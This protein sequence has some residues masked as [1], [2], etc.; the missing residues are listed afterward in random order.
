M[1][2]AIFTVTAWLFSVA[3]VFAA[4]I[5]LEDVLSSPFPSSLIAA[6]GKDRIA[7]VFNDEGRR[8]IWVA[9]GPKYKPKQLTAY[10]NDDGQELGGMSFSPDGSFI[11]YVRGGDTNSKNE[12]PNPTS[13]P[14]GAKQ[15]VWIVRV[16]GG[17][18]V[19]LGD[20]A[21][22]AVSADSRSVAF[23]KDG[24]MYSALVD[25]SKESGILFHARGENFSP[26]WS[27]D[28]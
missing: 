16:E 23:V 13:D 28:G 17:E 19:L 7:W 22:P 14:A 8:N 3:F 9:D 26:T 5:V 20:G 12:N 4:G 2:R 6:K 1:K 11:V 21:Y 15:Q 18:P 27:P 10:S 24:Q 25:R